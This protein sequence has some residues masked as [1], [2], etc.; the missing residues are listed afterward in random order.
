M[1]LSRDYADFLRDILSGFA[2]VTIRN[3]FGG[4]GIFHDGVMFGLV[5]D[6]TLY[7]RADDNSSA[8]FEAEGKG[9][10][11][12]RRKG[13]GKMTMP[14]WELPERLLD[15]PD[16]LALWSARAHEVARRVKPRRGR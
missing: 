9:P 16:E 1:A 6:D 14:Y 10:F 7:L 4:A 13:R 15:N 3:M 2:P 8:P 12:Y 5:A 11:T